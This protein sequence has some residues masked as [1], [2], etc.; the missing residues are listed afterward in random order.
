MTTI[1]KEPMA[2]EEK[3]Q[4]KA[5]QKNQR[6]D[7]WWMNNEWYIF[8]WRT[9]NYIYCVWDTWKHRIWVECEEECSNNETWRKQS[10]KDFECKSTESGTECQTTQI[11]EKRSTMMLYMTLCTISTV[12]LNSVLLM[13]IHWKFCGTVLGRCCVVCC[14]LSW[15]KQIAWLILAQLKIAHL[16]TIKSLQ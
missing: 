6:W 14:F 13:N 9:T 3:I 8:T 1:S 2:T 12:C 11:F 7:K 10:T 15:N 5:K 16:I 4:T